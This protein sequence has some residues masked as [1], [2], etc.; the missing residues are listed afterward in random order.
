MTDKRSIIDAERAR[1]AAEGS[2]RSAA[3]EAG[4][5]FGLVA[6]TRLRMPAYAPAAVH[7]SSPVIS[8]VSKGARS[9]A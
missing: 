6:F 3:P 4:A 8:S 2:V 7:G 9:I 1:R 5:R